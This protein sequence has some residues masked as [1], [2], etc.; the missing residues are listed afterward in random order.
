MSTGVGILKGVAENHH[1]KDQESGV[2]EP[3][4][5]EEKN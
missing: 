5:G 4:N 3:G 1:R 2:E